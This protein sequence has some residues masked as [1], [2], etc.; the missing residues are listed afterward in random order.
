MLAGTD[1]EK[2]RSR[3]SSNSRM[4]VWSTSRA[5]VLSRDTSS[6]RGARPAR[7]LELI[8]DDEVLAIA[9]LR[10]DLLRHIVAVE[11]GGAREVDNAPEIVR[12][13]FEEALAQVDDVH[14]RARLVFR[15]ADFL[16]F[17]QAL[18][19]LDEE[20]IARPHYGQAN[21]EGN[22]GDDKILEGGLHG[23][24]CLHL[25]AAIEIDGAHGM[26][27]L[28]ETFLAVKD[29]VRGA[30][31]ESGTVFLREMGEAAGGFRVDGC[32][33]GGMFFRVVNVGDGRNVDDCI[34]LHHRNYVGGLGLIRQVKLMVSDIRGDAGQ[35]T[36]AARMDGPFGRGKVQHTAPDEAAGTC[37]Q[38][39]FAHGEP[40]QVCD[41]PWG[42]TPPTAAVKL[43]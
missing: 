17:P 19:H 8:G 4:G 12:R 43:N 30:E 14:G 25:G 24:F 1:H 18:L 34:W 29:V 38:N 6:G 16:P 36:S 31:D 28:V 2:I 13:Q 23:H 22:A 39:T 37:D 40:F 9:Q 33:L 20:R 26:V 3:A 41:A 21:Y 42:S 5:N 10:G 27:F 32:C 15:D 11:T 7:A 35:G